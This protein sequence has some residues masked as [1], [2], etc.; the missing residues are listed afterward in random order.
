MNVT[1]LLCDAAEEVG[2]KLYILGGGWSFLHRPDTPTSMSLAVKISVPWNETNA[3]HT[4]R[5]HLLTDDGV[6][7]D[8]DGEVV[9]ATG[10]FEVGRP[11]GV[12]P[13]SD[14]DAPFVIPFQLALPAG[15][16]VWELEVDGEPA[17][18][19]PFRVLEP[20]QTEGNV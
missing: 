19:V 3:A 14:L 2:G 10:N 8:V 4:L 7:V 20:P 12:K 17:A 11:P 1:M 15:G 16:Y 13:G 5:A 9:E 18:R 6:S